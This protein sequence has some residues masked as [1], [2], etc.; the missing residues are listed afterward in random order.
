MVPPTFRV[1]LS[2]ASLISHSL[3]VEM[4]SV[5]YGSNEA[6]RQ[7][8]NLRH[9]NELESKSPLM[10]YLSISISTE[11]QSRY[12]YVL[13]MRELTPRIGGFFVTLSSL[14]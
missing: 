3:V 5:Y 4:R 7:S 13:M 2:R 14:N 1:S 8:S 10:A 9:L 6:E 12:S 11:L